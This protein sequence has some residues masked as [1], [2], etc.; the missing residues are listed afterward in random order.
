[1]TRESQ[2]LDQ[3]QR[4]PEKHKLHRV[5]ESIPLAGC[6][7]PRGALQRPSAYKSYQELAEDLEGAFAKI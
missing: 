6:K 2:D 5:G 1:M 4:F 7:G 3:N